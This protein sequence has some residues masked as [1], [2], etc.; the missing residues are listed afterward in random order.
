MRNISLLLLLTA[1]LSSCNFLK[2]G[3]NNST[4]SADSLSTGI[5]DTL[6]AVRMDSIK[7]NGNFFRLD[8]ITKAEFESVKENVQ[9]TNLPAGMRQGKD[10]LRIAL[11]NGDSLFLK[12]IMEYV[13]GDTNLLADNTTQ[14]FFTANF[15]DMDYWEVTALYYEGTGNILVNKHTGKLLYI[16]GDPQLSPDKKLF[17]SGRLDMSGE[18]TS[19]LDLYRI[20]KDSLEQLFY[21]EPAWGVE[22]VK[23]KDDHT[24]YIQQFDI[25]SSSMRYAK[26]DITSLR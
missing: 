9:D 21:A 19:G 11:M 23:W 3:D 5:K 8:S 13:D 1:V 26:L 24:L 16:T 7:L 20:G 17:A 2:K 22:Q 4:T 6:N 12:N 15:N 14:Y 10:G 25:T 18:S